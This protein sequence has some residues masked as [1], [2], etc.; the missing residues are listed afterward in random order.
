[1]VRL[2]IDIIVCLM[3]IISAVFGA[4]KGF[5]LTLIS[6]IQWFV[7]IILAVLL[8][9]YVKELVYKY[10]SI[11]ETISGYFVKSMSG[12]VQGSSLYQAIPDLFSGWVR[13]SSDQAILTI[14]DEITSV[15]MTV[16]SFL[17]IIFLIK[18]ICLLFSRLLSKKYHKGF[19][20]FLDGCGGFLLG[21]VRGAVY[22]LIG[23]TVL[24]P[25]LSFIWPDVANFVIKS[26]DSSEISGLLYDNNVLLI[27]VRDIF[28]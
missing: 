20:G 26:M 6:F 24:I 5:A 3:V 12:S 7:C 17:A 2:V 9:S 15:V 22:V 14:A 4:R 21:T 19:L 25:V 8:N 11:D 23:M 28:S 1:M 18:L 27:A 10:T 13:Y 16:L